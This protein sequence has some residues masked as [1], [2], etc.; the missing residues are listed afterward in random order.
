MAGCS[1]EPAAGFISI[2]AVAAFRAVPMPF[3]T[4][5]PTPGMRL[6]AFDP[7]LLTALTSFCVC[8]WASARA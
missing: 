6:T 5:P 3:E 2:A 7:A 4:H 8:F 1:P